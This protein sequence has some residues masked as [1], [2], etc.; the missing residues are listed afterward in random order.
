MVV[1]SKAYVPVTLLDYLI[2]ILC[3]RKGT[4][5][6]IRWRHF[7]RHVKEKKWTA[8]PDGPKRFWRLVMQIL[9]VED[10]RRTLKSD[11]ACIEARKL[12]RS[13][14]L[15]KQVFEL[16]ISDLV[17]EVMSGGEPTSQKD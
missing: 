7:K 4:M 3:E 13:I 8:K 5:R 9:D 16:D 2:E 10:R 6:T 12:E 11:R 15:L 14:I 17:E 1:T